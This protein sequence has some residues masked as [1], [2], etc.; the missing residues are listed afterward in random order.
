MRPPNSIGAQRP[1][2]RGGSVSL[3]RFRAD[4]PSPKLSKPSPETGCYTPTTGDIVCV[5]HRTLTSDTREWW[6]A[7]LADDVATSP[8]GQ[9]KR[10]G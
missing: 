3:N 10:P 9:R 6:A 2:K 4:L 7:V 8:E 1:G 5:F